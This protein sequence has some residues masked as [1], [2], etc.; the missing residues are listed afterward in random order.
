MGNAKSMNAKSRNKADRLGKALREIGIEDFVGINLRKY[1]R[2]G[3]M[4]QYA[5]RIKINSLGWAY[6]EFR[7]NWETYDTAF[8][9]AVIYEV[10]KTKIDPEQTVRHKRRT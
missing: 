1:D 8:G 7:H 9:L 2:W 6:A 3:W 10:G 4:S 5:M